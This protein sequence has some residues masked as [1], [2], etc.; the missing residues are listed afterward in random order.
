VDSQGDQEIRKIE[1]SPPE[2]LGLPDLVT[3]VTYLF[4]LPKLSVLRS[5]VTNSPTALQ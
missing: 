2:F 5:D 1:N 3:S 4:E